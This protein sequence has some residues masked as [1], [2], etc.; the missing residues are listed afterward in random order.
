MSVGLQ[1]YICLIDE[2]YDACQSKETRIREDRSI[3]DASIKDQPQDSALGDECVYREPAL[4][5]RNGWPYIVITPTKNGRTIS[6]LTVQFFSSLKYGL[7]LDCLCC[8]KV[9]L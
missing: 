5:T 7:L 9:L 1:T 3:L 2:H 4:V 8:Q 6:N